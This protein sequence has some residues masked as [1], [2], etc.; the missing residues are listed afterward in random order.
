M[1]IE[2]YFVWGVYGWL[3]MYILFHFVFY[4]KKINLSFFFYYHIHLNPIKQDFYGPILILIWP[5]AQTS[6]PEISQYCAWWAYLLVD[7]EYEFD[8][9]NSI[10]IKYL[11]ASEPK[12][13]YSDYIWYWVKNRIFRAENKQKLNSNNSHSNLRWVT[14]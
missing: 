2:F 3:F 13:V 14:I 1:L 11:E 8:K 10:N 5:W 6:G 9:F 7:F 4:K 12:W